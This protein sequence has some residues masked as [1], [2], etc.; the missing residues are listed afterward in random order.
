MTDT[1]REV[2]GRKHPPNHE[3][4]DPGTTLLSRFP[5]SI[6]RPPKGNPGVSRK[7]A[8][9]RK[10]GTR[11]FFS[12]SPRLRVAFSGVFHAQRGVSGLRRPPGQVAQASACTP[13]DRRCA[14]TRSEKQ[15][16]SCRPR[17]RRGRLGMRPVPSRPPQSDPQ[18]SSRMRMLRNAT[19]SLCPQMA[20]WPLSLCRPTK[21]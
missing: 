16:N 12:A 2:S 19:G 5:L 4:P 17:C 20:I 3:I 10:G 15:Q 7:G 18:G 6:I 1:H 21:S 11:L 13:D 8:P 14:K 9:G